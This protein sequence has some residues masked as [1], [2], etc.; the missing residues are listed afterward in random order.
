MQ[1]EAAITQH[2]Q[3]YL[4][5]SEWHHQNKMLYNPLL[6]L[7]LTRS[8]AAGSEPGSMADQCPTEHG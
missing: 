5:G 8:T 7:L 3:S 1:R 2:N 4:N 6:G